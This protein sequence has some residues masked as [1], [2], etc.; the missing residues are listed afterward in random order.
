MVS[1]EHDLASVNWSDNGGQ[2]RNVVEA[3]MEAAFGTK[4]RH[5]P[6]GHPQSNGLVEVYNRILDTMH[7]G[8]RARFATAVISYNNCPRDQGG[9]NPETL[10]RV[11]RPLTS[12]WQNA[13]TR[14]VVQGQQTVSSEDW[15]TFLEL[16]AGFMK[17]GVDSQVFL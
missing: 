5:I 12:R 10:W 17:D 1:Q 7:G 9:P 16:H 6:P 13:G 15:E 4:A 14:A 11:L 2:F 8:D 3:A